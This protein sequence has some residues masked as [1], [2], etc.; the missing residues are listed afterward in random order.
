[1]LHVCNQYLF[2]TMGANQLAYKQYL[3]ISNWI[4][5]KHYFFSLIT[6]LRLNQFRCSIIQMKGVDLLSV[7]ILNR[8][9]SHEWNLRY[10]YLSEE[11]P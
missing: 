4:I 9:L 2:T 11:E 6:L 10:G 5:T 7:S 1:M 8:T 3:F